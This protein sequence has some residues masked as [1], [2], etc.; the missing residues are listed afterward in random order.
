MVL[1]LFR[2]ASKRTYI[3]RILEESSELKEEFVAHLE[4]NGFEYSWDPK[5]YNLDEGAYINEYG[6]EVVAVPRDIGVIINVFLPVNR[7]TQ[8]SNIGDFERNRY[9]NALVFREIVYANEDRQERIDLFDKVV[10][11]GNTIMLYN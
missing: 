9:F 11:W 8:T 10:S 5:T 3:D 4:S 7:R 2:R 1:E 6:V